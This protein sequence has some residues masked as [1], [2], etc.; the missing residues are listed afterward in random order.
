MM[1]WGRLLGWA[2]LMAMLGVLPLLIG[3]SQLPDPVAIHWGIDGSPDN[4]WPKIATAFLPV[5]MVAI[6]L[7]TTSLF[8][9]EGKPTAEA[10]AIVGLMGGVGVS[11][12]T[13]LVYL[14]WDAATW[15]EAGA[16]VWW[17]LIGIV[18][19]GALGAWLGYLLGIRW[20]P[21]PRNSQTVS[22]PVLEIADD[23]SVSWIGGCSVIWPLVLLGG[24]ALFF[25]FMPGWLKMIGLVFLI[26]GFLF[27]RVYVVINDHGMQVRLGGGLPAKK[28]PLDRIKTVEAIDLEPSQWAGWGYRV[29]PGGSAVVLR[30]GDA[31]QV[32]M[33]N[34]RR[35]AV[36]VDDAATG[37]SVL[38][39]LVARKERLTPPQ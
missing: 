3:W 15:Q 31:I 28:I 6:G 30:R 24:F 27:L 36:T 18:L 20:Y 16:F 8:R 32:N 25:L 23:E 19:V 13:S 37:A 4:A 9:I 12:M 21:R 35:F 26:L 5:G 17:H 1:V 22:G 11:M 38:N 10:V 2:A 33:T 34:D 29:V 14:N 7:F 39:G